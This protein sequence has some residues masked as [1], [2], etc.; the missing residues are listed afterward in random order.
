MVDPVVGGFIVIS[1]VNVL[2]NLYRMFSSG[3]SKY[4][5]SWKSHVFR[6]DKVLPGSP[7]EAARKAA[8]NI[9]AHFSKK[10]DA[11][12]F[13]MISRNSNGGFEEVTVMSNGLKIAEKT[14]WFTRTSLVI[15][16]YPDGRVILFAM[17]NAQLQYW[18]DALSGKLKLEEYSVKVGN[19]NVTVPGDAE[20]DVVFIDC[21]K[22]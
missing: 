20:P 4:V 7:L 3:P 8:I 16:I 9:S 19:N 5:S 22:V 1:G 15:Q 2:T 21:V 17:D 13:T 11:S 14:D 6:P 12:T 10:P 18:I